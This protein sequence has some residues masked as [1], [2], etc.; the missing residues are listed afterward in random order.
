MLN[1]LEKG[2]LFLLKH[3][4]VYLF[5]AFMIFLL[6]GETSAFAATNPGDPTIITGGQK[7][8]AQATTWLLILIPVT[9]GAVFTF[10][11]WMKS[12]AEEGAEVADRNKKMKR[13]VIWGPVAMCGTAIVKLFFYYLS[14]T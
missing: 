4:T 6:L 3:K 1:V 10:H 7:L 9:S 2:S 14:N 12:H 5:S 13:L 8:V 11:A